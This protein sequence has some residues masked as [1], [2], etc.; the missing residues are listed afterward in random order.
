[1]TYIKK[2]SIVEQAEITGL[3]VKAQKN[4]KRGYLKSN[5]FTEVKML[6]LILL[7]L[8]FT[9]QSQNACIEVKMLPLLL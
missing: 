5:A 8:L 2:Q 7:T 6:L 1:M 4:Y 3:A 9:Y